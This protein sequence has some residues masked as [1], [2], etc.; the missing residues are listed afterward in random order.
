M[1]CSMKLRNSKIRRRVDLALAA[2]ELYYEKTGRRM[3]SP[4]VYHTYTTDED[5][6]EPHVTPAFV[7]DR[8]LRD[9]EAIR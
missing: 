3:S 4:K 8:I 2:G 7:V 6:H 1:G 9:E 5:E